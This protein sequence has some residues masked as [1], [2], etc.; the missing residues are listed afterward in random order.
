MCS[1]DSTVVGRAATFSTVWADCVEKLEKPA[2][3]VFRKNLSQQNS[4]PGLR[5]EDH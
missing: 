1:A 4:R 2:A 5:T 3:L